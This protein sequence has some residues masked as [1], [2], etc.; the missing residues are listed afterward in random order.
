MDYQSMR[1]WAERAIAL[2]ERIDVPLLQAAGTAAAARGFAFSGTPDLARPA[3]DRSAAIVD[4]LPDDEL[5]R[6][7]DAIVDLAGAELSLHRFS[8]ASRHAQRALAI[9][10]ATGQHQLFPV[11]FAILG[12]TWMF[13]GRLRESLDALE[14]NVEAARLSGNAQTIAWA[15][16]GLAQVAIAA[17]DVERGLAAAQEA[18]D[19]ADDGKPSHHVAYAAFALAQ[20]HVLAGK[21]ERGRELI[22]RASGGPDLPLVA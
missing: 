12:I 11:A 2:A 19:V 17:G 13:T 22:V 4:A 5:A 1:G 15:L 16:Y 9:G 8:D 18:V 20:A 6:R 14:G 10:R 7:L 3:R 21:P